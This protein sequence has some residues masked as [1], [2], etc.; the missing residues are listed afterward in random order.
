MRSH[1]NERPYACQAG[2]G[3]AFTRQSDRHRHEGKVHPE[4]S[5][6]R[7]GRR[8][9]ASS[10]LERQSVVSPLIIEHEGS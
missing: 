8:R 9:R 5:F 4:M 2:C 10:L 7:S 3:K 6:P 1:A